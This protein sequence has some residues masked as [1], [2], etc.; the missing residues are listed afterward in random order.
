MRQI[1]TSP[2]VGVIRL[3]ALSQLSLM[4]SPYQHSQLGDHRFPV[5]DARLSFRPL[6]HPDPINRHRNLSTPDVANGFLIFG[7]KANGYEYAK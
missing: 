2:D 4:E 7:R 3:R 5:S 1:I 6:N